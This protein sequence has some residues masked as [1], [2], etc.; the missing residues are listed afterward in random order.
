MERIAVSGATGFIG[1]RLCSYLR[2][3]G[4]DVVPLGRDLFSSHDKLKLHHVIDGVDVVINLAGATIN[5][6]WSRCAKESIIKS[7]VYT[8]R[9]IVEAMNHSLRQQTLI[10]ASAVGSYPSVGCYDESSH[11]TK[12]T[13]FLARV[14]SA[15]ESEARELSST[16]RLIIARLGVVFDEMGGALPQMLLTRRYGFLVR[17]G[18]PDR[19]IAWIAR[20]DL[21]RIMAFLIRRH[22]IEGVVNLT[23]PKLTLQDDILE[24]AESHYS[25]H[26]IFSLPSVVLSMVFGERS[27]VITGGQC[28]TPQRLLDAGYEFKYPTVDTIFSSC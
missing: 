17:V 15:W 2:G 28:V 27:E 20:E 26:F 12:S 6:C 21:V 11:Y 19:P 16:K 25:T 9:R 4:Y 5:Q 24:A 14:C 13:A 18:A 7:R 22:D 23:S 8:T 1:S 10:S 3:V